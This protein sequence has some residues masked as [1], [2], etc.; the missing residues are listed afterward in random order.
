MEEK[1]DARIPRELKRAIQD[2]RIDV[3]KIIR[4]ALLKA[5]G[6]EESLQSL[7]LEEEGRFGDWADSFVRMYQFINKKLEARENLIISEEA[8]LNEL[9]KRVEARM[10]SREQLME[11]IPEI[12]ALSYED[13]FNW[14]KIFNIIEKYPQTLKG[15][16][17]LVQ[18]REAV[19]YREVKLGHFD[20]I[21]AARDKLRSEIE[22]RAEQVNKEMVEWTQKK[23]FE[24]EYL[25]KQEELRIEAIRKRETEFKDTVKNV[26]DHA[27]A[28]EDTEV[29]K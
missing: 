3:S 18:I 15:N 11:T 13:C 26:Y 5:A 23:E 7:M 25:I 28:C 21:Q 19:L 17:G 8:R 20:S 16:V 9:W 4:E 14:Q 22:L 29:V 10:K 12:K 2:K 27:A 24:R 1:I 6:M